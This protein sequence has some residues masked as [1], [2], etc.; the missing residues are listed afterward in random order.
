MNIIEAIKKR[1]SCR[2]YKD[3]LLRPADKKIIEDSIMSNSG[4]IWTGTIDV[5]IIEKNISDK[6]LD[7][8][9]GSIQGHNTYLLGTSIST[10]EARVNYGYFLEKIVLK[11][12]QIGV[13]TCWIGYF[14]K[15]YFDEI[16]INEGYEIPGIVIL[17][18]SSDKQ[19][20]I[21]KLTRL[22]VS[23]SK[24]LNREKLFLDY[25]TGL[26]L[27]TDQIQKYSDSLEMVRL[28]PSSGNTQPWRIFYNHLTNEFHF[29]KNP[30]SKKYEDK[31]FH[32]IDMGIALAHFELTSAFN[33]LPGMWIKHPEE[34]GKKLM[35]KAIDQDK[36]Q[37]IVWDKNLIDRDL[38]DKLL[39]DQIYMSHR[40]GFYPITR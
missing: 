28:G 15:T 1:K 6:N 35:C 32:D 37:R 39:K 34:I 4:F 9:Y 20:Y 29:F 38:K 16:N 12:T 22:T 33:G 31:G 30:V 18:Y 26:P 40:L 23:A 27:K 3:I 36:L 24:R 7:L 21:E 10:P 8:N 14:D 11:A 5:T 25:I 13:S 2:S 19:T 17:G